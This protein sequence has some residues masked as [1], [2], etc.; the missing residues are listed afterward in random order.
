MA[1]LVL[2][3]QTM[4]LNIRLEADE[5]YK[6]SEVETKIKDRIDVLREK[7]SEIQAQYEK[8]VKKVLPELQSIREDVKLINETRYPNLKTESQ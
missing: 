8:E 3:E 5:E 6:P 7:M 4:V 1:Y 2:N